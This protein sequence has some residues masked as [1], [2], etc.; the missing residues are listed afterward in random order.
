MDCSY[1]NSSMLWIFYSMPAWVN[2]T[3]PRHLLTVSPNLLH[4]MDLLLR[5]L[6][7]IGVLLVLCSILLLLIL[8]SPMLSSKSACLCMIH[9][10]HILHLSSASSAMSRVPCPLVFTLVLVLWTLTAYS[11]AYW[12]GCP[13]SRR[14]TSGHCVYLGDTLVSWSSKIQNMV[15]RSSAEAEY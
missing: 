3:P 13:D 7:S 2:V 15:S 8:T 10:S 12:A 11:N 1:L 6:L 5:V 14:S 9:R 4:Y